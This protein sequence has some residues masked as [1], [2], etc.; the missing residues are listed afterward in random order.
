MRSGLICALF[1]VLAFSGW[2]DRAVASDSSKDQVNFHIPRQDAGTALNAFAK[3]AQVQILFDYTLAKG[4]ETQPVMGKLEIWD[5]LQ[6]LLIDTGLKGVKVDSRRYSVVLTDNKTRDYNNMNKNRNGIATALATLLSAT[7][8]TGAAA[9]TD[10]PRALEEVVVTAQKRAESLQDVPVTVNALS[11]ENLVDAGAE[12]LFEVANLVPGMVFSR[13]PDDGLALTLRGLGTPARTQSFDQSVALFLDGT[14]MG[15]GRMY[16][17]AFFDVERMEII[18]G[19]QSTLLGKNSSLGAISIITRKPGDEFAGNIKLSAELANGGWGF[20]GG[21]DIPVT[22]SFAL[23]AA[24]HKTDQDGW[25]KNVLTGEDVPA[26][27]ETGLRLTGVYTPSDEL[28]ATV[29][30]QYSESIRTGNGFQYVDK[31]GYF[32]DAVIEA[33]GEARLDDKKTALCPECPGEESHHDTEVNALSLTLDYAFNELTLTSIT[34]VADYTIKFFDDFDFGH[35][36]DEVNFAILNPGELSYYSTYFERDEDYDQFS[37]ELRIASPGDQTLTYMAGL[38]YFTSDWESSE[39][40][41]WS[42]PNFPPPAIGDLSQ[43]A[44]NGP[45]TNNFDQKT[46]SISLFGQVTLNHTE[47]LRSTLGLRY[48]DEKKDVVFERVQGSPATLWN[49]IINPPFNKPLEF[50]D[51]FVNGNLNVQYDATENAMV[52]FSYGVG[53][54]TGGFAESAEVGSADPELSVDQAG[55]RV[56][57]EEARTIEVGAKM[58]LLDNTANLNIA[59]FQTDIEDFQETS[60]QVLG[61]AAAFFL[62]RNIDAKSEGVELDGQWQATNNLRVSGG[63]TYADAINDEDGTD[64]AQAPKLTGS[65]GF[66]LEN[67]IGSDH[68]L[69]TQSYVRYRDEMVSQINETFPSDSLTTLDLTISLASLTGNWELSLIGTN[70]TDELSADFSAPPAAPTGAIFGAPA[71]DQGVVVEAPSALRS[72]TLQ[73]SYDF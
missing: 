56:E 31:G 23:R 35:A 69:T 7:T 13:A 3:Q 12:N 19:T 71:G 25:V 63:L 44:F 59:L 24:L 22:D 34:S 8:T 27:E 51:S 57:T 42:T 50:D 39:Q 4:K 53:S 48:T 68:L 38:F 30:Y 18:K 60:F 45:F 21:M 41:N 52:Y 36:L 5:A 67:N 1:L 58:S 33:M 26:D 61:P 10:S 62:T 28:T 9:Q 17:A 15:K 65:L 29:S 6:Q 64:L 72:V 32:N 11:S 54:K 66:L 20:D 49:T 46:D 55:A 16:S 2:V 73:F 47:R 70:I 40:Q 43:Q 37:Q 14:F